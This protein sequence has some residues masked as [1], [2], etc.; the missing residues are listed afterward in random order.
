[1]RKS[2]GKWYVRF[3]VDGVEYSK[4]TGLEATE[5]NRRKAEQM[6]AQARQLVIEGKS[7][8]LKI[9]SIPFNEAATGFLQWAEGEY[10]GDKRGTYLRIRSSF[11]FARVFFDR[12][13]VSGITE[14]DI[15]D[16]KAARRKMNVKEISIRH[17]LHALSLFYQYAMKKHWARENTIRKIEIPSDADAV[18]MNV[19]TPEQEKLYFATCLWM[20]KASRF[21]PSMNGTCAD[22]YRDLYDF[23]R[24]MIQQGCR[25]EEILELEKRNVDLMNRWL[26]VA[27]GKTRAARRRLKLTTESVTILRAVSNLDQGLL[28][29]LRRKIL[30]GTGAPRG[31]FMAKCLKQPAHCHL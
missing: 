16:F 17:D 25:P 22:S 13:I 5:R 12:A 30:S 3:E 4:P 27:N 7:N 19:L 20:D 6:E 2:N 29:F 23:G 9:K 11:G 28:C 21:L 24:L 10:P 1:M 14:G 31:E 15:E 8:Y 18:R 26:Y